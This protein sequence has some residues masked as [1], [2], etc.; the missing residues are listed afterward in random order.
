[1]TSRMID[2]MTENTDDSITFALV[3]VIRMII[4]SANNV[5][6]LVLNTC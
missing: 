4:F 6:T 1:M 2:A 3:E 5:L